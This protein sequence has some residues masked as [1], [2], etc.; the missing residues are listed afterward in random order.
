MTETDLVFPKVSEKWLGHAAQRFGGPFVG[1][2]FDRIDI[3]PI[4]VS[5]AGHLAG[6]TLKEFYESPE[7]G[8]SL[9]GSAHEFYDAVP[10]THWYYTHMWLEELGA[11]LEYS[12]TTPPICPPA[13]NGPEEALAWVDVPDVEELKTMPTLEKQ[14]RA[15][16]YVK[17][18]MPAMLVPIAWNIDVF[19]TSANTVGA[20]KF[21]LWTIKHPDVCHH[22]L[23][24]MTEMT[25]NGAIAVAE[26]F[27]GALLAG[28]AVLANTQL[29]S[30]EQQREFA[31]NY[32]KEW[33]YKSLRGGA[34][35]QEFIHLCGD[36]SRDIDMWKEFPWTPL[37]VLNA[38]YDKKEVY[39]ASEMKEKFGTKATIMPGVDTK[40]L[41]GGT[42]LEVYEQAKDQILGGKDSPYGFILGATCECPFAAQPQNIHAMCKAAEDYGAWD[43]E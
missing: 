33:A 14:F 9:T 43:N 40:L 26:E 16:K 39:P 32:V 42:P 12:E 11:P 8:I 22:V 18:H 38:G 24:N 27:G 13:F 4:I 28:G 30:P 23:K 25:A 41:Y 20:D 2:N 19:G 35:P 34:G 21:L 7:L 5:H 10:V 37:A 3:D 1:K 15:L 29:L 6:Y 17:E 36:R 31:F